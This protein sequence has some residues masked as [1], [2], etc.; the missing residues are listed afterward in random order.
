MSWEIIIRGL[1]IVT[2]GWLWRAGGAEGIK[3]MTGEFFY[4]SA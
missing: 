2:C 1:S 4:E 3:A